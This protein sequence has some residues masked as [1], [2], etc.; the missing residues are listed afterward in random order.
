M[1]G[2]ACDRSWHQ[3]RQDVHRMV[4]VRL[5]WHELFEACQRFALAEFAAWLVQ[6]MTGRAYVSKREKPPRR[7]SE[8]VVHPPGRS[9]AEQAAGRTRSSSSAVERAAACGQP[10]LR[11]SAL[12]RPPLFF[13]PDRQG[14][15]GQGDE[16]CRTLASCRPSVCSV[17]VLRSRA[18]QLRGSARPRPYGEAPRCRWPALSMRPCGRPRRGR[19]ECAELMRW[20]ALPRGHAHACCFSRIGLSRPEASIGA[21]ARRGRGQE[22]LSWSVRRRWWRTGVGSQGR[23]CREPPSALRGWASWRR[24]AI[25]SCPVRSRRS[26]CVL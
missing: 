11:H 6:R 22:G 16:A 25:P 15:S 24:R 9:A 26:G 1:E 12:V 5:N 21:F 13:D 19:R 2:F 3:Y 8:R 10:A 7:R 17:T 20:D 14:R 23:W 18:L 4:N